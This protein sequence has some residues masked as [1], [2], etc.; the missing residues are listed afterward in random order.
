LPKGE[1]QVTSVLSQVQASAERFSEPVPHLSYAQWFSKCTDLEIATHCQ[2]E[3]GQGAVDE[4][5]GHG[6]ASRHEQQAADAH[7]PVQPEVC[8]VEEEVVVEAAEGSAEED[9][10]EAT[11]MQHGTVQRHAP[12]G[13]TVSMS[14]ALLAVVFTGEAAVGVEIN[15]DEVMP[16]LSALVRAEC[17]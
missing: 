5:T 1:D 14:S 17:G 2:G 3:K 9:A 15:E 6:G 8:E 11:E 12:H 10:G 13:A 4:M 16:R 7:Q